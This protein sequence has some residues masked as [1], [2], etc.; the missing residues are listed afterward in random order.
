MTCTNKPTGRPRLATGRKEA[1]AYVRVTAEQKKR[2]TELGGAKWV[3]AM[4]DFA[5]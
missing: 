5:S 4:I 1:V 3:R 2:L